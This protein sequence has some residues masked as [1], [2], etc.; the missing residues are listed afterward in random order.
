MSADDTLFDDVYDLDELIGS[1]P[2]SL[3]RKCIHK[4]TGDLFA[5]K[6]VDI[7]KF[8]STP[9]LTVDGKYLIIKF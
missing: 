9:G 1:G 7:E 5:V 2:Y 6:I 8:I 3:V 4:D